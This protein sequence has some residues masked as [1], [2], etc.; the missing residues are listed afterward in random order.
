MT[1]KTNTVLKKYYRDRAK[2]YESVYVRAIP[3]RLEEQAYIADYIGKSLKDKYILEIACGT[4]Y[5]TKYLVKNAKKIL[6]TDIN[7]EM[8]EIASDKIIDKSVQFIIS[9]AYNPPSSAPLFTGALAN[10]WFS[11]IPKKQVKKFLITLHSRLA[12]NAVVIFIDN[13][14]RE[15]LGG[16]LVVKK[17]SLD[18]WK[19]RVVGNK[20]YDILKNYYSEEELKKIF[21]G[22]LSNLEIKYLSHFW[23][24][25]Y[26]VKKKGS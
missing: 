11:H 9:D 1:K 21:A 6:A 15:D 2:E 12:N 16:S 4:G 17:N 14:Y 8:L 3:I 19:R 7:Q 5:W 25:S 24:V 22:G 13:V 23:V 20:K 10:F 26:K 18:T